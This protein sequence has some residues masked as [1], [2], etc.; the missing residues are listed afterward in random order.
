MSDISELCSYNDA[1][2][3]LLQCINE[4]KFIFIIGRGGNG[5]SHLTNECVQLLGDYSINHEDYFN[6][7]QFISLINGGKSLNHFSF[8]PFYKWNTQQ[9]DN[10]TIIDMTNIHHSNSINVRPSTTY[11]RVF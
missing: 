10:V 6:K 7:T 5:K 3:E 4:A 11:A 8:N 1:K 2:T 9:P